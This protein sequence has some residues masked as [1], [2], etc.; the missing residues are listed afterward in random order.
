MT[1]W[2]NKG[3]EKAKEKELENDQHVNREGDNN[4]SQ[5]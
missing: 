1:V 5:T 4:R 3:E 2:L